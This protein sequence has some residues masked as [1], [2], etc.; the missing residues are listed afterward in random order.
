MSGGHSLPTA[1]GAVHIHRGGSQAGPLRCVLAGREAKPEKCVS[2]LYFIDAND[3]LIA[4]MRGVETVVLPG[5][6]PADFARPAA[7]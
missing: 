5:T 1:A 3:V 4:E 2:D 6:R 7:S